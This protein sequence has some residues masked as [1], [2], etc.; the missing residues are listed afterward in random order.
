L[1]IPARESPSWRPPEAD[2]PTAEVPSFVLEWWKN[3]APDR[4]KLGTLI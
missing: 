3:G 4:I 2:V 1:R